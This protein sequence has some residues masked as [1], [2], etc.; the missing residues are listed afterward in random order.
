MGR[1]TSKN[2]ISLDNVCTLISSGYIP[3]DYGQH[4]DNKVRAQVFCGEVSTPSSEFYKANQSGFKAEVILIVNSEE[5]SGQMQVE[6]EG[7]E[8]SINR[9]FNR[10]Y[11]DYTELYCGSRI[12][13]VESN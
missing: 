5:F 2:D 4:T 9:Y 6:Y 3:G 12:G 11:D 10:P 8:Y 7:K 13:N 1:I